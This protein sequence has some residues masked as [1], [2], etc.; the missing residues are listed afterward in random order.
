MKHQ[1]GCSA[2]EGKLGSLT[3]DKTFRE[4]SRRSMTPGLGHDCC[5]P[6]T[7]P[8]VSVPTARKDAMRLPLWHCCFRRLSSTA[9]KLVDSQ[10]SLDAYRCWSHVYTKGCRAE[11][12]SVTSHRLRSWTP[13][14]RWLLQTRQL[15]DRA[16]L[17]SRPTTPSAC[18]SPKSMSWGSLGTAEIGVR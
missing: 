16:P 2:K 12:D 17:G 14:L 3:G 11:L 5:N 18:S 9:E 4:G 8:R 13:E 1:L 15:T 6:Q 10:I 7:L